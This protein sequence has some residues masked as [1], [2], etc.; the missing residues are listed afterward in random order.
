MLRDLRQLPRAVWVLLFGTFVNRFGSFVMVFLALYLT[1]RGFSAAQAGIAV[2]AYG[3]GHFMAS[4][5]GGHLADRVGRRNTIAVSMFSSAIAM[6]VLSQ[7]SSYAAIVV[8][9]FLAGTAAEMYRPAAFALVGDLVKPEQRILSFAMYRLSVNLGMAAGPATAGFLADRSFLYVFLGDA[10]TSV[11]Y[12]L[13]A[14]AALP[15][16]LRALTSS[17]RAGAAV[18][19]AMRDRAFVMFLLA[20]VLMTVVDFQS[21]STLPLFVRSLGHSNALFGMLISL[22]GLLVICI[23]LPMT[24]VLRRLN[25]IDGIAFGYLLVGIGFAVNAGRTVPALAASVIIWTLGEIFSAPLGS[26][27]VTALAPEQYRG[28]YMGMW[29]MSW[30]VGMIVGPTLGTLLYERSALA[31]WIASGVVG[32]LSAAIIVRERFRPTATSR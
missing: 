10:A 12:G 28:R 27:Y 13:I 30:A 6:L 16:G 31:V 26:T 32:T 9:T 21:M 1:R 18:R 19:T 24:L 4:L 8:M 14:L 3:G 23:E 22:N 20:T 17:E 25:V 29:A 5:I 15:H 7:V 2:A 11:A